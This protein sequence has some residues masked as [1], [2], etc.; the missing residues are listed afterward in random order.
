MLV[1]VLEKKE[2]QGGKRKESRMEN[3]GKELG[4][5]LH[6]QEHRGARDGGFRKVSPGRPNFSLVDLFHQSMAWGVKPDESWGV[7]KEL[8]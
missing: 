6:G 8:R 4:E 3:T 2:V 7:S 5:D 1:L